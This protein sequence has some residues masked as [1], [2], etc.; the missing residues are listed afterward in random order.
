MP[1][2]LFFLFLVQH[3]VR[4]ENGFELILHGLFF[5]AL[6]VISRLVERL[7]VVHTVNQLF[8]VLVKV[9]FTLKSIAELCHCKQ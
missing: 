5:N 6:R 7:K 1:L 8:C 4:L 3:N 2:F 9:L